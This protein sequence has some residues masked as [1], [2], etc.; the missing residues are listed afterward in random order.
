MKKSSCASC[1]ILVSLY[2]LPRG[3]YTIKETACEAM[4]LVLRFKVTA[5]AAY[6]VLLFINLTFNLIILA[7]YA[8][9]KKMLGLQK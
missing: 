3:T 9:H 8:K 1:R 2:D 5:A 4:R 7:I 6:A